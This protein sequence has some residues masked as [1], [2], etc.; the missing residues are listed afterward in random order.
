MYE[1]VAPGATDQLNSHFLSVTV[2]A[3][4]SLLVHVMVPPVLIV[5]SAVTNPVRVISTAL[6]SGTVGA[7][8]S[9]FFLSSE[10]ALF[11]RSLASRPPV[12]ESV[13][14]ALRSPTIF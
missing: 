1:Y 7:L 5:V 13:L 4:L 9:V 11:Q 3:T 2:C 8:G 14:I 6:R 12:D 10:R